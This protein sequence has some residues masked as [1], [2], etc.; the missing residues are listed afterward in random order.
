MAE[1][2]HIRRRRTIDEAEGYLSLIEV[3]SDRFPL[4]AEV[5]NRIADRVLSMLEEPAREDSPGD[6][7]ETARAVFLQG[8]ALRMTDRFQEAVAPLERSATLAPDNIHV[9]LALG[10]CL[11]RIGSIESAIA[12]LERSLAIEPQLAIVHYNLACYWS[13]SGEAETAL[14]YLATALEIDSGYRRLIAEEPDFD[15]IRD[16]P[17]FREL[18]AIIV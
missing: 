3:L 14:D 7:N 6:A 17:E 12:W 9:Y 11:K 13:L 8:Q 2:D 5:R 16:L 4:R 1:F 10:W 15:P 18:T